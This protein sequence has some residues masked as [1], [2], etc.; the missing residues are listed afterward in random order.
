M[1]DEIRKPVSS[2]NMMSR[3]I[4]KVMWEI[5]D[6]DIYKLTR[7]ET[8]PWGTPFIMVLQLENF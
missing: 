5:I 8:N 4:F 7:R 3:D 1:T 6:I 2:P